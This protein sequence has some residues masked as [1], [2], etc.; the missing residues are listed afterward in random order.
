M[1]YAFEICKRS[2]APKQGIY[3]DAF[4]KNDLCCR[5][6][7]VKKMHTNSMLSDDIGYTGYNVC[8]L[9]RSIRQSRWSIFNQYV[10]QS[11]TPRLDLD[12]YASGYPRVKLYGIPSSEL[13]RGITDS[14]VLH[15]TYSVAIYTH[16]KSWNE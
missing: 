9:W 2:T 1:I 14:V 15:E 3:A 5:S 8:M 10:T 16:H 7:A 13:L 4:S 6:I 11:L 12:I